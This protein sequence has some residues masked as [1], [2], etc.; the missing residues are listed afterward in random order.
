MTVSSRGIRQFLTAEQTPRFQDPEF[1]RVIINNN[2]FR[3][4]GWTPRRS[5]IVYRLLGT[6]IPTDGETRS[7]A[8]LQSAAGNKIVSTGE[9][10]GEYTLTDIQRKQVTLE[11]GGEVQIL[12]LNTAPWI[13]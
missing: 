9:T 8:I 12:K 5:K 1:Y 13:K 2:L 3:P 4:L 11:K 6:R 10:F 7:Q